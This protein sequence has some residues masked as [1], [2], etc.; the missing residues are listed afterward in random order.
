M[1]L[2]VGTKIPKGASDRAEYIEP[3][4]TLLKGKIECNSLQAEPRKTL[5]KINIIDLCE[6]KGANS[7]VTLLATNFLAKH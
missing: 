4:I 1:M 2:K 6:Y 5:L 7:L 3:T